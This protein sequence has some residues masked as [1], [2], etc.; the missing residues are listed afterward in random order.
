ML[1]LIFL[2]RV[3]AF[4]TRRMR[5]RLETLSLHIGLGLVLAGAFFSWRFSERG[6]MYLSQG[7]QSNL[8]EVNDRLWIAR[9]APNGELIRAELPRFGEANRNA[10]H[11]PIIGAG[12][13]KL[14]SFFPHAR[15][16]HVP[17]P[18]P[19]G[20]GV[21]AVIFDIVTPH[22]DHELLLA[23]GFQDEAEVAGLRTVLAPP[24]VPADRRPALIVQTP[25]EERALSLSLPEDIGKTLRALEFE[26]EILDYAPAFRVGHPSDLNDTETNP[27][28]LLSI[29]STDGAADTV[30]LFSRFPGFARPQV[31]GLADITFVMPSRPSRRLHIYPDS[32]ATW[33]FAFVGEGETVTNVVASGDTFFIGQGARLPMVVKSLLQDA[34]VIPRVA[35][36]EEGPAAAMVAIESSDEPVWLVEDGPDVL[37]PT[38]DGGTETWRLV[39]TEPLPFWIR[40]D[41]AERAFYPNSSIPRVYASTVRIGVSPNADGSPQIVETNKPL[42]SH[43]WRAFQSEYGDGDGRPWSGLLLA[44]DPG[45]PMA[46]LGVLVLLLGILVRAGWRR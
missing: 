19:R 21:P 1:G 15:V 4:F 20:T 9:E 35:S 41:K 31:P 22:G 45:A 34:E 29:R 33:L 28:L 40:L 6:I 3:G 30:R 23:G 38:G 5:Q 8:I 24:E 14:L 10:I 11:Q 36:A 16:D 46:G 12:E 43:G 26:L 2:H 17:R 25:T 39:H 32:L 18:V 7:Q 27:A 42:S 44:K 13:A 37:V